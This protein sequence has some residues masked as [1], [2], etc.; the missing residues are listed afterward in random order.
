[1]AKQTDQTYHVVGNLV[2]GELRCSDPFYT[3]VLCKHQIVK[4]NE[5]YYLVTSVTPQLSFFNVPAHTLIW[6]RPSRYLELRNK[7]ATEDAIHDA[8]HLDLQQTQDAL[9]RKGY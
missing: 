9:V 6:N 5:F 2:E 8:A 1:M 4:A 3:E 7:C